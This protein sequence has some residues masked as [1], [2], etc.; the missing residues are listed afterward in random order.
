MPVK[1]ETLWPTE[2]DFEADI[3]VALRRAFPWLPPGSIK[4]QTKFSF[5]FGRARIEVDGKEQSRATGR[6]DV[7]LYSGQLPLAV[8]ELKRAGHA[9]EGADTAQGLSDQQL[10]IFG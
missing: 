10:Y 9:L 8:L 2:A 5:D 1:Q 3:Q 7:L 4:H 6:A